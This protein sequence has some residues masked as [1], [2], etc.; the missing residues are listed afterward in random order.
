[1]T[2]YNLFLLDILLYFQVKCFVSVHYTNMNHRLST[3]PIRSL[4]RHAIVKQTRL[5]SIIA[6]TR[7]ES[8]VVSR[9]QKHNNKL[10]KQKTNGESQPCAC[11]LALLFTLLHRRYSWNI[12]GE[13]QS[14][15]APNSN[16]KVA[17][18]MPTL[19]I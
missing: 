15:R 3:T 9:S 18:S 1:M 19:D 10:P 12:S 5:P 16:R 14:I 8:V 6:W 2:L 17:S 4:I 13:A 7:C 11:Q